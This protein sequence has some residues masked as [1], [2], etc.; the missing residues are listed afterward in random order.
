LSKTSINVACSRKRVLGQMPRRMEPKRQR[1]PTHISIAM[2]ELKA[3]SEGIEGTSVINLLGRILLH[4]LA[5]CYLYFKIRKP[6][7]ASPI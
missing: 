7:F 3:T 4:P 6:L 2:S 5:C 1:L